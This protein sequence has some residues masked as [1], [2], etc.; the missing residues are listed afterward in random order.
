MTSVII[1]YQ[2]IALK[3]RNRPWFVERLLHNLRVATSD[4]GVQHVRTL[5]GRIELVLSRDGDW[6]VLRERLAT[7]FGIANFSKAVHTSSSLDTLGDRILADLGDRAP[8]SFA[9]AA[10]RADKR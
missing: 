4:L 3:G 6:D 8:Q 5:M 10:R 9:I 2:E 1:H 7:T